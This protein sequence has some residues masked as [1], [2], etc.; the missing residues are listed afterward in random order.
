[1]AYAA[2]RPG[3]GCIA[4]WA[5]CSQ[6]N[7]RG[8]GEAVLAIVPRDIHARVRSRARTE[9][10]SELTNQGPKPRIV[11]K[12]FATAPPPAVETAAT[13]APKPACAGSSPNPLNLTACGGRGVAAGR[14]GAPV[15]ANSFARSFRL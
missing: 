6:H 13:P 8:R 14:L 15:T 2:P 10:A 12:F 3:R 5:K 9:Y 11:H 7:G 1:P 4:A